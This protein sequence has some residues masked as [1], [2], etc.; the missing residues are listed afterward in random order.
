MKDEK[1]RVEV[2]N[3]VLAGYVSILIQTDA[4]A[5]EITRSAYFHNRSLEKGNQCKPEKKI[6]TIRIFI[7]PFV[8]RP[9]GCPVRRTALGPGRGRRSDG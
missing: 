8:C 1:W 5:T 4:K 6:R 7:A 2:G 9:S 3:D